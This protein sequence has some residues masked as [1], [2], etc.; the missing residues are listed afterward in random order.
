M[1]VRINLEVNPNG[2]MQQIDPSLYERN[3]LVQYEFD[4]CDYPSSRHSTMVRNGS[5]V[6]YS[7]MPYPVSRAH[8]IGYKFLFRAL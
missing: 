8:S 1:I 6:T 3:C 7:N 4:H 5:N 2:Y